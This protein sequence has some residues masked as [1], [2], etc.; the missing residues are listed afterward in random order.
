MV[1]LNGN[2]TA[3]AMGTYNP[4]LALGAA[5]D[6]LSGLLGRPL[7]ISV[8]RVRKLA[9]STRY[10]SD[11]IARELGYVPRLTLAAG[12]REMLE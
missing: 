7:P 6:I 2:V 10:S 12:L 3:S 4:A 5:A 1:T 11:R 8:D 9:Q